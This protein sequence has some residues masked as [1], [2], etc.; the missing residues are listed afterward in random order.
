MKTKIYCKPTEAGIHTF[1]LSVDNNVY[2]LFHQKYRKG[3]QQFFGKGRSIDESRAF[4][5]AHRDEAILRT[6]RKLPAYIHYV[7]KEN[8]IAVYRQTQKKKQN[9]RTKRCA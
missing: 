3:V 1:Y 9:Q 5:K 2:Y 8:D 4:E 7:E 6:M